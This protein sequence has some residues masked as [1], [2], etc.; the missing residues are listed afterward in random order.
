MNLFT[1]EAF[2]VICRNEDIFEFTQE[3][4]LHGVAIF[5]TDD[6]NENWFNPRLMH[7]LGI[8]DAESLSWK[9]WISPDDIEKIEKILDT[10][11]YSGGIL[12]G[13]IGFLHSKGFLIPMTYKAIYIEKKVVI[14]VKK[15]SDYSDIEYS[16]ELN[17]HREQ[18]LETILNTINIAVIACDRNGK[19]TLFNEAAKKWH[20]LPAKNIPQTEWA[21]YYNLYE[22]DGTLFKVEDIPLINMLKEGII[23]KKE[24]VIVAKTG[25]KR[26]VVV[27]GARLHDVRNNI[28]GA[29]IAM[30]NITERKQI[31]NQLMISEKM[32]RGTFENAANGMA[33]SDPTGK[34]IETNDSL[35]KML[36]FSPDELKELNFLD[37]THPEDIDN[38]KKLMKEMLSSHR[39]YIQI[40]KRFI[41][42]NSGNVHVILSVSL[43]KDSNSD[44]LYMMAQMTD[45]SELKSAQKE[46][47]RI[48]RI[49]KDQNKRLKN[50]AQ[51]VS[52]NLKS[53]AGNIEMLLDIYIE[54]NPGVKENEIV[55]M[56]FL[57]S[58][59]LKE[60]LEDLNKVALINLS[61]SKKIIPI[62]L[63]KTVTE[64]LDSING[65]IRKSNL[66]V[67]N[68]IPEEL[69]VLSLPAYMESIILN[70]ATNAIKYRSL[71]REPILRIEAVQGEQYVELFIEDNGLGIDLKKFGDKLFG[72]YKTFHHN[73]DAKG[74]GLFITKNQIEAIGGKVEVESQVDEGTK[75]KIYLKPRKNLVS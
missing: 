21:E 8:N 12:Y 53:N 9:K 65:L 25:R 46:I 52:H 22:P 35:S 60:T 51:I 47:D 11:K 7:S 64:T 30:Y 37:I 29:V 50:F 34:F 10:P 66:Q 17:Y 5:N 27:N 19:L 26:S 59:K 48:L 2:S 23:R 74:I 73:E 36:G 4:G 67:L 63:R 33:I 45:I 69:E 58:R 68:T 14:A 44:P 54:E 72:M 42:K 24:M 38:D 6:H 1:T 75:F 57:A 43:V 32:F 16:P 13:E 55:K 39:E 20:G 56:A 70:F 40:E 15:V 61:D 31:E 3:H 41:S 18:L 62:N 71:E 28:S 49:T